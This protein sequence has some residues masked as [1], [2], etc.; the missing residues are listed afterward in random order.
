MQHCNKIY[1]GLYGV[2]NILFYFIS[3]PAIHKLENIFYKKIGNIAI[4]PRTLTCEINLQ[5]T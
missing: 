1:D 5:F 2:T 4:N 3:Y